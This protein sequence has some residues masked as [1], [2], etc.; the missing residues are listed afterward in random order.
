MAD[1]NYSSLSVIIIRPVP[2]EPAVRKVTRCKT[3]KH[4]GTEMFLISRSHFFLPLISFLSLSFWQER[5]YTNSSSVSARLSLEIQIPKK[6]K[7]SFAPW[8]PV[9]VI[10]RDFSCF[11]I[12]RIHRETG[13]KSAP[14]IY[15]PL[16]C[17]SCHRGLSVKSYT[18][19]K[20][21]SV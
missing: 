17:W 18:T 8:N 4:E 12:H 10:S 21:A 1:H 15:S 5:P 6:K 11:L 20:Q 16:V 3:H 19:S 7:T 14:Y 2:V 9:T 13:A